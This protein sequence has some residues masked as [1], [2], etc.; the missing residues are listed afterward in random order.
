MEFCNSKPEVL[1]SFAK[2]AQAI[3][4]DVDKERT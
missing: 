2:A 3:A 1:I 4:E